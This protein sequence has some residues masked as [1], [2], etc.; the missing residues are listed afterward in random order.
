[1]A[2]QQ[3]AD[4]SVAICSNWGWDLAE[5]LARAGVARLGDIMVSSAGARV[6]EAHPKCVTGS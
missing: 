6:Q 2:A 5:D 1:M 3:S 4:I